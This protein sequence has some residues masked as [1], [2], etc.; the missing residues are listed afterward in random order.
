MWIQEKVKIELSADSKCTP[1][2]EGEKLKVKVLFKW[3]GKDWLA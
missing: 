1:K 2:D 3:F